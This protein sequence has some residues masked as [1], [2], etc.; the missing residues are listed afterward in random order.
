MTSAKKQEANRRN[1]SKSTGPKTQAGKNVSARNAIRHGLSVVSL[2]DPSWAPEVRAFAR[3]LVAPGASPDLQEQAYRVAAA[4][5]DLLRVRRARHDL[6]ST[7][8][9][10]DAFEPA[11]QKRTRDIVVN[12]RERIPKD[13]YEH[14]MS[15][16][17]QKPNGERRFAL[18]FLELYAQLERLDRYERR[19]LSRRR[20]AMR[21]FDLAARHSPRSRVHRSSNVCDNQVERENLA[22][23]SH[24]PIRW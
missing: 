13:D 15:V 21:A 17:T 24:G 23:R 9:A 8:L 19:A 16:L 20:K 6:I 3:S 18:V 22:E 4:Q 5:I 7:T 1:A 12:G 2:A 14:L 10:D 11:S